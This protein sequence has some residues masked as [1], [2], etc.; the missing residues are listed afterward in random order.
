MVTL[1]VVMVKLLLGLIEVM[2]A[3]AVVTKQRP[4]KIVGATFLAY[5]L[6]II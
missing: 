4:V 5:R 3:V 2:V 6:G 1:M